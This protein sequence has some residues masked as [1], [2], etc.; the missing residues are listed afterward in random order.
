M[1]KDFAGMPLIGDLAF[2]KEVLQSSRPSLVFFAAE[3]CPWCKKMRPSLE[4]LHQ[5]FNSKMSFWR[6]DI[7]QSEATPE[8]YSIFSVPS[9]LLFKE[10]DETERIN[11]F[12]SHE[13][14]LELIER[15]V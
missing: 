12:A 14:I 10:G 15:H 11:G 1:R 13:N 8:K 9:L 6:V 7:N 5:T 2:D 3:W 4:E